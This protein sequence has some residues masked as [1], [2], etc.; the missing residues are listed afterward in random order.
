MSI[1]L[2][3]EKGS[4]KTQVWLKDDALNSLLKLIEDHQED[5]I[6]SQG[7]ASTM[8]SA[9]GSESTAPVDRVDTVRKWMASH[10][11]SELLN[12][13]LWDTNAEKILL[14]GAFHEACGGAEGWRSADM[15]HRFSEAK[16]PWPGNFSRD[17][18]MAIKNGLLATVTPRTYKISRTGW[19]K[20]SDTAAKFLTV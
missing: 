8:S 19:N 3:F 10:T 17:V 6:N 18:S 7:P 12:M 4:L 5:E 13:F 1:K 11:A 15:E 14:L 9:F 16:E 2:F 20:V